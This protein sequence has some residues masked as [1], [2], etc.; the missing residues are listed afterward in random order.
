MVKINH[1][2]Y[3]LRTFILL[4]VLLLPVH[5]TDG[6]EMAIPAVSITVDGNPGDW[7]GIP[8]TLRDSVGD[9]PY[10][11]SDITNLYSKIIGSDVYLMLETNSKP[12]YKDST[13]ELNLDTKPGAQFTRGPEED[14]HLNIKSNG[15]I[16]AWVDKNLD[17]NMENFNLNPNDYKV[18]WGDVLEAKIS[19][20]ALENAT[21]VNPTFGNLWNGLDGSNTPKD[22]IESGTKTFTPTPIT[23]SPQTTGFPAVSSSPSGSS[24]ASQL[25]LNKGNAFKEA[26]KYQEA[27][28]AFNKAIEFDSSNSNAWENKGIVLSDLGRNQEAFD[29]INKAL[30]LDPD[31]LNALAHKAYSLNA[32]GKRDEA[33]A[34]AQD[35]LERSDKLISTNPNDAD[36]WHYRGSFLSFLGKNDEAV[37]ALDKSISI[38]PNNP[39]T[40][41]VKGDALF[42]LGKYQEAVSAYDRAIAINPNLPHFWQRKGEALKA[43]GKY[44]EANVAY[45]K[46]YAITTAESTPYSEGGLKYFGFP[47]LVSLV[48]LGLVFIFEKREKNKGKFRDDLKTRHWFGYYT[49]FIGNFIIGAVWAIISFV[50]LF[51][52]LPASFDYGKFLFIIPIFYLSVSSFILTAGLRVSKPISKLNI[53][54]IVISLFLGLLFIFIV[55]TDPKNSTPI[56]FP[57]LLLI[58]SG[59]SVW[60]DRVAIS[61]TESIQESL[62]VN[63]EKSTAEPDI[64]RGYAV[65]PNNDIKFGIRVSNTTGYTITDVDTI[66]DHTEELFKLKK[67]KMQRIGNLPPENA[68]TAEYIL[69]P[70]GCIH[71][72]KINA[73]ISYTDAT[74]KK[75]ALHMRPKEVHCVCPFLKEKPMSEG[76]YSRLA[77]S[78]EFVQEGISFKG[79]TVEELAK[80]MGETCRHMLYKIKEYD[81]DGK[82]VIY[83][84]GESLGEK[85][86]Y[87]LTA[88]IQEY[89]GL[90]QVVLRAHSDKKHGLN[91]FMNEMADSIRHLVGSMQNAK[92]IGIIENTQVINIIDSVVQRTNFNMGEGGGAQVHI[93]ESVVQRS[94]I[95]ASARKCPNCGR[96]VEAN[97]KFCLECGAKLNQ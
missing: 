48:V 1:F 52:E 50:V 10:P 11:N 64:K 63:K 93:K 15:L 24:E 18:V 31:N 78:S 97:E 45:D 91:G 57:V 5:L 16:L 21:Y 90:T 32:L 36:A 12:I 2:S 54:H 88:V 8:P 4:S 42:A 81:L 69:K 85:A 9:T 72:E 39:H 67:S 73:L 44:Q 33:N 30:E 3:L 22:E 71:N 56:I 86:Y 74:G 82:K 41:Y 87:L 66:L 17:G 47:A 35:V 29:A 79:I 34:V 20:K 27:L 77:A 49:V 89:K 13:F 80:F 62:S 84:S 19:L 60:Y 70:L 46:A 28:N 14:F 7:A 23:T 53:L 96:E 25:W 95:G 68:R 83:L 65:L 92:E 61:R 59:I 37:V 55:F 6:N 51:R 38:N 75:H 94:T 58:S 43:L 26:G 76:E 40:W